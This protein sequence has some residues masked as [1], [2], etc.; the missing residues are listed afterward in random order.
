MNDDSPVRGVA[1]NLL[2][3]VGDNPTPKSILLFEDICF[4]LRTSNGTFRTTFRNR[5]P[6][7]DAIANQWIGKEL[8]IYCTYPGSGPSRF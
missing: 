8:R 6:D 7:L 3:D 5:F 1:Y 4:T 2:A